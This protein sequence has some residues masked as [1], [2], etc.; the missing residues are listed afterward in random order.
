MN[1]GNITLVINTFRVWAH[2][3]WLSRLASRHPDKLIIFE[4]AGKPSGR[5]GRPALKGS[6][7]VV[8]INMTACVEDVPNKIKYY[9]IKKKSRLP[10]VIL[11]LDK[12]LLSCGVSVAQDL[13]LKLHESL[14][15]AG[16][17]LFVEIDP[18]AHEEKVVK[19]I[20]LVSDG[21]VRFGHL[22]DGKSVLSFEG[23]EKVYIK[24][25]LEAFPKTDGLGLTYRSDD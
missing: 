2:E 9:T 14:H 17:V 21:I 5:K 1:G 24:G 3:S 23:L 20:E 10:I 22:R 8:G 15:D 11:G 7:R 12:I 19:L 6:V 4:G 16:G 18:S 25:V 13:I